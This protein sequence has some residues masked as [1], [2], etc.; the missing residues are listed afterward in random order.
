MKGS[1]DGDVCQIQEA[2]KRIF[3][4]N[5]REKVLSALAE[6]SRSWPFVVP[7]PWPN[8]FGLSAAKRK[9]SFQT[10]QR[11]QAARSHHIDKPPGF[12]R[13]ILTTHAVFAQ[14]GIGALL[15]ELVVPLPPHRS[16]S[17][18]FSATRSYATTNQLSSSR[19]RPRRPSE[20]DSC[21]L[22]RR[23]RYFRLTT[24]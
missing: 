5:A 11:N 22:C 17:S 13:P 9:D 15:P 10:L 12:A 18:R 24:N 2:R 14:P 16:L 6:N 23:T 19:P 4:V 3:H 7:T 8:L 1:F 21:S 20:R